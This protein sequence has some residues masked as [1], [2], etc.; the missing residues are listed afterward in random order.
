[1]ECP[2]FLTHSTAMNVLS[3]EAADAKEASSIAG[4]EK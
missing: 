2:F 1:M 4:Y 3:D